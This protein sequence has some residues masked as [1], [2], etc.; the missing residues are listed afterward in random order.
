M[1]FGALFVHKIFK[2]FV[3]TKGI[4]RVIIKTIILILDRR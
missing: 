4:K 1:L 3:L 2:L